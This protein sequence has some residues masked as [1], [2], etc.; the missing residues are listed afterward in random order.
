MENEKKMVSVS[1]LVD[2]LDTGDYGEYLNDY[3]ASDSYICDAVS[4]IADSNTSIYYPDIKNF[5]SENPD[6]FENAINEYGWEG[7]GSDYHKAGQMA[8]YMT[9][10]QDIYNH[11][12]DSIKLTAFDYMR[13]DLKMET[14]SEELADEIDSWGD[15]ADNNEKMSDITEKIDAWLSEE[16]ENE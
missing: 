15:E 5:I 2:A 16:N 13:Y 9:I 4:E 8:E 11:L 12:A 7:C 14:I 3:R 10:E 6:A 1:E